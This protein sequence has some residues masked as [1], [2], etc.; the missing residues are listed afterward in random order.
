MLLP[1]AC[2]AQGASRMYIHDADT[3]LLLDQV[4]PARDVHVAHTLS[5]HLRVRLTDGRVCFCLTITDVAHPPA[6]TPTPAV[7][8]LQAH[9]ITLCARP[10]SPTRTRHR[11]FDARWLCEPGGMHF[12]RNHRRFVEIHPLYCPFAHNITDSSFRTAALG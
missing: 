11:S 5:I 10:H 12:V 4:H 1:S 6:C 3:R 8:S 7:S 2:I 9:K